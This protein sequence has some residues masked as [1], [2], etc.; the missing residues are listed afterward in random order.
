MG[1]NITEQNYINVGMFR[2]Y[3]E[4]RIQTAWMNSIATF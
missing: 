1:Y 4:R 3:D 2:Y